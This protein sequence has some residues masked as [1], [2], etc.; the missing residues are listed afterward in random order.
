MKTKTEQ[1][2]HL[3]TINCE[4]YIHLARA[5]AA[6]S[7]RY[8]QLA[9]CTRCS[10]QVREETRKSAEYFRSKLNELEKSCE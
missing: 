8:V 1:S 9:S 2:S 4:D 3:I 6:L 7:A 10:E 5:H